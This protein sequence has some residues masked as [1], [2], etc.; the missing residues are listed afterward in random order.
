MSDLL[1][2]NLPPEVAAFLKAEA[3]RHGRSVQAEV[4]E[5]L[6]QAEER[7]KKHERFWQTADALREELRGRTFSDSADLIR[8]DRDS[9]HGRGG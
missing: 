6:E 5:M 9:D 4:V 7:Q 2:R 3:A 8:E 1:I